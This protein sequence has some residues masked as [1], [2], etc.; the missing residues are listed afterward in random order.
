MNIWHVQRRAVDQHR[1]NSAIVAPRAAAIRGL[2]TEVVLEPGDDPAPA[3]Q[4]TGVG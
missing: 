3:R 2:P 1:P 4:G